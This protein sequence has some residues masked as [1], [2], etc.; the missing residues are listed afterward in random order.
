MIRLGI[1]TLGKNSRHGTG[2]VS[3]GVDWEGSYAALTG[4]KAGSA[5][6]LPRLSVL[7]W[8]EV[9]SDEEVRGGKVVE[10]FERVH[11]DARG[12]RPGSER[13]AH[14]GEWVRLRISGVYW[15]GGFG[16][17]AWIGWLDVGEG[18]EGWSGVERREWEGVRLPGEEGWGRMPWFEQGKGKEGVV[19]EL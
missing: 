14:S 16:D 3:L 1:S 4:K 13:G 19:E 10:C 17:R 8:L 6:A 9:M 12:W 2:N 7:G 11:G 5:A 15:V 18:E